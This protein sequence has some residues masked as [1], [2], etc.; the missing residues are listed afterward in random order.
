[1]NAGK[2]YFDRVIGGGTTPAAGRDSRPGRHAEVRRLPPPQEARRGAGLHPL[3]HPHQVT[4]NAIPARQYLPRIG[5]RSASRQLGSRRFP[6]RRPPRGI[7]PDHTLPIASAGQRNSRQE[8]VSRVES[9]LNPAQS[10]VAGPPGGSAL[11]SRLRPQSLALRATSAPGRWALTPASRRPQ[12][13][14]A[15]PRLFS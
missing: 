4:S 15:S 12:Q 8:R 13:N 6:R 10:L 5:S 1:M 3:R 2:P 14:R 11:S 9:G 7:L